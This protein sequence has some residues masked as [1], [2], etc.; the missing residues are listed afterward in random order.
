MAEQRSGHPVAGA[1]DV[2]D[3]PRLRQAIGRGQVHLGLHGR[4]PGGVRLLLP[5][6]DDG[7]V[8]RQLVVHPQS[9]QGGGA[10]EA[11]G[12]AVDGAVQAAASAAAAKV[13]TV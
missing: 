7:V 12:L 8:G 5:V 6:P 3:L 4:L 2:D 9:V 1:V 13:R 10:A 11:H